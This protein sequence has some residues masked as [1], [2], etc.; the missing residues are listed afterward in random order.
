MPALSLFQTIK[1]DGTTLNPASSRRY[2]LNADEYTWN[3]VSLDASTVLTVDFGGVSV[4]KSVYVHVMNSMVVS[5][6]SARIPLNTNGFCTLH[7]VSMAAMTVTN[8]DSSSGGIV[9]IGISGGA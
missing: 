1:L 7:L 9:R 5:A 6:D 4:A 2:E 8:S 3:V